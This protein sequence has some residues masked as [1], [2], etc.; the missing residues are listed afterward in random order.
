MP[1]A[2]CGGVPETYGPR[3]GGAETEARPAAFL[4]G[5]NSIGGRGRGFGPEAINVN[6]VRAPAA[7]NNVQPYG[8]KSKKNL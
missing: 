6:Q 5:M 7:P 3:L 1:A 4:V 8:K 2:A